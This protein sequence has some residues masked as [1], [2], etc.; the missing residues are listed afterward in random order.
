MERELSMEQDAAFVGFMAF[1]FVL[2]VVIFIVWL[3]LVFS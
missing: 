2:A 3:L 1:M